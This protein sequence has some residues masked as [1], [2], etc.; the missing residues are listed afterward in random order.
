MKRDQKGRFSK[1]KEDNE[2]YNLSLTLPSF[3]SLLYWLII[4]IILLP[5]TVIFERFNALRKIF[6]FFENIMSKRGEDEETPKKMVYFIKQML[7]II[8]LI[9]N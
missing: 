9:I 8:K 3:R 7:L 4:I 6:D 5:W 1:E 2:G